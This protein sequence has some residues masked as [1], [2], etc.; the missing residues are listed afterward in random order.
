MYKYVSSN[1]ANQHEIV[2]VRK[3]FAEFINHVEML[4]CTSFY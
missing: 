4:S 1:R 3:Y 2:N